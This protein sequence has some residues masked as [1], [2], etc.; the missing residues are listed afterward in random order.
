MRQTKTVVGTSSGVLPRWRQGRSS[1]R[2]TGG[3]PSGKPTGRPTGRPHMRG[4]GSRD[5][6]GIAGLERGW[7]SGPSYRRDAIARNITRWAGSVCGWSPLRDG[8]PRKRRP[9]G[10]APGR[11]GPGTGGRG[12]P[13]ARWAGLARTS[14]APGSGPWWTPGSSIRRFRVA[15]RIGSRGGPNTRGGTGSVH[16]HR[17][18][19][20]AG[21]GEQAHFAEHR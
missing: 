11:A 3:K 12:R 10:W 16:R 20:A 9:L 2:T 6:P 15:R 4:A 1:G 5:P 13:S 14:S 21:I 17:P 7:T 19:P 8:P 18:R